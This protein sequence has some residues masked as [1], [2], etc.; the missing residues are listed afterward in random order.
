MVVSQCQVLDPILAAQVDLKV[1]CQ[2]VLQLIVEHCYLGDAQ[3]VGVRFVVV[4]SHDDIVLFVPLCVV[5]KF[6]V[7]I[8][9]VP[10]QL[11]L[12]SRLAAALLSNLV[13]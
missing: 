10:L 2:I 8:D 9:P 1:S 6:Y 13:G 3:V 4:T 11:E 5:N 7:I 12:K